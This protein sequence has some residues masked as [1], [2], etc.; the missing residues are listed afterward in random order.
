MAEVANFGAN[1]GSLRMFVHVP[2]GL[3]PNAPLVVV[4]HGCTQGAKAHA[5]AAGWLTLAERYGFAVLAPEQQPANNPN[6][7]FNW[8][9]PGDTRRGLGEAESIRSMVTHVLDAHGLEPD[10]VFVTGLSAGGAMAGAL[11]ATYP[12]VFAAGAIV[13]GLPY[14]AATNLREALD[15][16]QGRSGLSQSELARRVRQAGPDAAPVPR[17]SV[18][19]GRADTTVSERNATDSAV[20]WAAA[21]GLPA[22]PS[23]VQSRPGR[24]VAV[25]RSPGGEVLVERHLLDGLGHGTPLKTGGEDP[26]GSAA[27]FMLEAGIS[28]SLEIARF[29]GIAPPATANAANPEAEPFREEP[30]TA[31]WPPENLADNV[32]A[33]VAK[34][35]PPDVT[36]VIEKALRSAGLKR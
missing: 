14:G 3:A 21:H 11:L 23:E 15:A 29:W 28:S 30:A 27:P 20:Q 17:V 24:T 5:S 13:A 7:C 6:R 34:H 1:P 33:A 18:W 26:I 16:M 2:E 8:F 12:D 19:H 9:E 35:V 22:E 32:V 10:R 25:W 31:A 36:Q 4:L